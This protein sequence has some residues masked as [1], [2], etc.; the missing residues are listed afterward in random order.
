MSGVSKDT[1]Q[2]SRVHMLDLLN[3]PKCGGSNAIGTRY[4]TTCG[5]SLEG[6]APAKALEAGAKKGLLGRIF[7]RRTETTPRKDL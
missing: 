3:C 2:D 7:G 4:C 5:A 1:Q 6:M